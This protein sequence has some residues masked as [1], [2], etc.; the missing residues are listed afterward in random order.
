MEDESSGKYQSISGWKRSKD[1]FI[2]DKKDFSDYFYRNIDSIFV[3]MEI[4]F[5][6]DNVYFASRTYFYDFGCDKK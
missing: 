6:Y 2:K 5:K 1:I 3:T 4:D